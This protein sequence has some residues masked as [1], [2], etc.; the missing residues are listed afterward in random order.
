MKQKFTF[1]LACILIAGTIS[2]NVSAQILLQEGFEGGN[3]PP[4]GAYGQWTLANPCGN[5]IC[6]SATNW[7]QVASG[8][9]VS[10]SLSSSPANAHG[11]Q[12]LSE[13][14]SFYMQPGAGNLVSPAMAFPSSNNGGVQYV[15]DFWVYVNNSYYPWSTNTASLNVFLTQNNTTLTPVP[16]TSSTYVTVSNALTST[17]WQHVVYTVPTGAIGSAGTYYLVFSGLPSTSLY[18]YGDFDIDDINL[19]RFIPC[20][21][22][23]NSYIGGP[24]HICSGISFNL[25]DST[26][27]GYS[28]MSYQWQSRLGNTTNVFTNI[29]AATAS[30]YNCTGIG[31]ATDYRVISHCANSNATDTS[32]VFSITVDSFY[33]CYCGPATNQGLNTHVGN[34]PH[35]D[36]V[37][38]TASSL[39]NVTYTPVP[40]P[41]GYVAF[42]AVGNATTV[43]QQGA[44]YHIGT[45]LSST[46]VHGA[47]WIDF[48]HANGFGNTANEYIG[49]TGPSS[50]PTLSGTFT[51][52]ANAALGLTGL[53]VR[54][55]QSTSNFTA[56]SACT[57]EGSG[58]T[59][60]YLVNITQAPYNDVGAVAFIQPSTYDIACA[61][62]N[63]NVRVAISNMGSLSQNNFEVFVNYWGP[64]NNFSSPLYTHYTN[65]LAGFANDTITVGT[66]SLPLYGNYYLNAYTYLAND[67]NNLNDTA[68]MGPITMTEVPLPPV[69]ISDTVCLGNSATIGVVPV[70]GNQYNWYSAPAGGTVVF[71]SLSK[72]INS[73]I[74]STYYF[75]SAST[76]PSRGYIPANYADTVGAKKRA[77]GVYF[78]IVP[79][80]N[81]TLDSFH[82]RFAD[83]GNQQVSIWYRISQVIGN[84]INYTAPYLD[85]PSKWI[86]IA[87][88]MI[89]NVSNITMTPSS[90]YTVVLNNSLPII[91]GTNI[92]YSIYVDYDAEVTIPPGVPVV[93]N[94]VGGNAITG[95][96][97]YY[98]NGM[99]S[100]FSGNPS[101]NLERL[102]GR[103]FYH[104][105]G[106]ACESQ[107]IPVEAAIGP[108]PV[109]NLPP[110]GYVCWNLHLYLDAGNP[111]SQYT[112]RE[113]A[114]ANILSNTGQQLP[115][116]LSDTGIHKYWVT[117]SRY[118]N[119]T[120]S[121]T[122]N[123]IPPPLVTGI[124]YTQSG[125]VYYL[126]VSGTRD[127]Q[128]YYWT[129]GDGTTSTL[130]NPI[131]DYGNLDPHLVRLVVYN[132]CGTDTV[133]WTLPTL[134]VPG[135]AANSNEIQLYPNPANNMLSIS[136]DDNMEIKDISVMNSIGQVVLRTVSNKMKTETIDVNRLAP[137]NYILRANTS[138]GFYNKMFEVLH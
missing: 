86:Q 103:V 49:M 119:T 73:L 63:V 91:S 55:A 121:T 37:G 56:S 34:V 24:H 76:P 18:T 6:L 106:S 109:V 78:D 116:P 27:S 48:D 107:R 137:G 66:L 21:G 135:I 5:T 130:P 127:V 71:D 105:G 46:G 110:S 36:S 31:L 16:A 44:T 26:M 80:T 23:P 13:F 39:H 108:T 131:H 95:G 53:R 40:F 19:T 128:S 104:L 82:L 77:G 65:T 69:V 17:G 43:L 50:S 7:G 60:D 8:T 102:N 14:P 132:V 10:C 41:N 67:Q 79:T 83:T 35:N 22:M 117:V 97:F 125:S 98:G 20:T 29:T 28:G 96:S 11:G 92:V 4:N 52:P 89:P 51:V 25:I 72:T 1:L 42:P 120:D 126:S 9:V 129:F 2:K 81:M 61:N 138:N 101:A 88:T 15:I 115:I 87:N 58:E 75:I 12:Y 118:C 70:A 74:N 122:L 136:G 64:A 99:N 33:R 57:P 90:L 100:S 123:I 114:F 38:I 54:T 113:D 112:W 111:S 3:F 68:W 45:L 133:Y 94:P 93:T 32:P 85:T 30:V 62:T 84:P 134:L 47:A 59:E 124:N